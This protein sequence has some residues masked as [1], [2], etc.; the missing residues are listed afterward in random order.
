MGEKNINNGKKKRHMEGRR[1]YY[2]K[3]KKTGRR[4][5]LELRKGGTKKIERMT[6]Y[7]E[8]EAAELLMGDELKEKKKSKGERN[9]VN[10]PLD[11]REPSPGEATFTRTFS[12]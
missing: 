3:R 4:Y 6:T 9:F 11:G 5:Q 12:G 10:P 2:L 8:K 7:V 1:S